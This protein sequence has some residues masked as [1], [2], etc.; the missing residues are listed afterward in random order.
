M[1]SV[2]NDTKDFSLEIQ[3]S[4]RAKNAGAVRLESLDAAIERGRRA[5]LAEQRDD[6]SWEDRTDL[7][8]VGPAMHWIVERQFDVLSS[9]DR[10]HARRYLLSQQRPDGSF[11][12]FPGA[13]H[14]SASATALCRAGL[15]ACDLSP[16]HPALRRAMAFVDANGGHEAITAGLQLRGDATGL[17][18]LAMDLVDPKFLPA[19]P[20]GLALT[21]FDRLIDRRVHAG[22]IMVT[23]VLCAMVNRHL[24]PAPRGMIAAAARA[25]EELRIRNYLFRWQ[26]PA[27]DWNGQAILTWLM[28]LGLAATGLTKSDPRIQRALGWLRALRRS[29][30]AGLTVDAMRTDIWSTAWASLALHAAGEAPEGEALAA[31]QRHLLLSQCRKPMPRVNQRKAS[32]VRAGGWPF[33]RGN[34]LMPDTDDTGVVLAALGTLNGQRLTRELLQATDQAVR[35][36]RDMQSPDGGFAAYVWNLPPKPPGPMYLTDIPV[37]LDSPARALAFLLNP[38]AEFSDPPAEGITGRVL[39]G[40]GSCGVGRDDPVVCRAIEFLRAQ[41]C[42]NGAWW[43]RW[44]ACYLAETATTLVGLGAVGEDMRAAY[45]ERAVRFLVSRQNPDGGFGERAEVYR[46]P[47]NAGCGPSMPPVTGFVL[48]GLLAAGAERQT[49][50]RAARY[51]IESQEESGLWKNAGWLHTVNPPDSFY[52]YDLPAK[53]LPLLA[54]CRYRERLCSSSA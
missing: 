52:S 28:L 6:G 18:L 26:N 30:N 38:P 1:N 42:P 31:A 44:M 39:W 5:L 8:P 24:R 20:A 25:A 51:L 4:S 36:L 54:L 43:G 11:P 9:E 45:V 2:S 13:L 32:A 46:D 47:A 29:D 53:A 16:S 35:W 40:L 50:E 10:E 37:V 34:E 48:L 15:I 23:L 3:P 21:P 14:G 19:L 41:Q 7:G 49:V 12:A 22:N 33:Q 17:F 27:G